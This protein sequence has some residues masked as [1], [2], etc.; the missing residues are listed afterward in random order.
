MRDSDTVLCPNDFSHFGQDPLVCA[1]RLDKQQNQ[2]RCFPQDRVCRLPVWAADFLCLTLPK[3]KTPEV[4]QHCE[5]MRN[6]G[7]REGTERAE[8]K[9]AKQSPRPF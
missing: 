4:S 2:R 6:K 8:K 5:I 9:S 1:V 3:E 7:P